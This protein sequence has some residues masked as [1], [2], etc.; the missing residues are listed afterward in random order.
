MKKLW[1]TLK[2][3]ERENIFDHFDLESGMN[4]GNHILDKFIL[5]AP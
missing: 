3:R 4:T 5:L 2:P 1:P